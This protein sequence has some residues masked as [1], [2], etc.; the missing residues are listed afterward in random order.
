MTELL[1]ERALTDSAFALDGDGWTLYGRAVPYNVPA[2]V[3]DNGTD[4][5]LE[6][7]APGAFERDVA[8]GGRWVSLMVGHRGDDGD[9]YLGRCVELRDADDGLYPAFRLERS[10]PLAEEARSGE[11]TSWS[12][13]ARVYRSRATRVNGQDVIV[14]ELAG[15]SHVAA[16]GSPQYAGAGV[17][18]AREHELLGPQPTPRLD[19]A[20]AIL[21]K[22]RQRA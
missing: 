19:E 8:K 11:L 22:L 6:M 21:D 5:Y 12:V 7:W 15:L 2:R 13:S 9:R 14:R 17:L 1:V 16:T 20:R 18:V 10:H 4:Y 3:T